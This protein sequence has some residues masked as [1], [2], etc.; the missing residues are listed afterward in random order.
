MSLNTTTT[1]Q[2]VRGYT[3]NSSTVTKL[4]YYY[5]DTY[6]AVIQ[7]FRSQVPKIDVSQIRAA[8]SA[9]DITR[10]I[11][12]TNSPSGFVLFADY[13]HAGW[14]R[15]FTTHETPLR[16]AQ[17]FTF[18]NPLYALPILQRNIDVALHIPLDCC[19]VEELEDKRVKLVVT[20][21]ISSAD[22]ADDGMR[23]ALADLEDKVVA[24]IDSLTPQLCMTVSA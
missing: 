18:G 17:R 1:F 12:A 5:S 8:T 2:S 20:L 21:P 7:R 13:N 22:S 10:V 6:E 14:M 19:F 23:Q 11:E 24:L 4:T 3:T 9:Q 15:H 16:R